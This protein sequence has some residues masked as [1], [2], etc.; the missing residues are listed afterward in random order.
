MTTLLDKI[1]H[2]QNNTLNNHK[3]FEF[4]DQAQGSQKWFEANYS[5]YSKSASEAAAIYFGQFG[6]D[7]NKT[8]QLE[9]NLLVAIAEYFNQY[10]IKCSAADIIVQDNVFDI[11][12]SIYKA[13]GL[14]KDQKVLF[15]L[16]IASYFIQQCHDLEIAVEFLNTDAK[17][18][19]KIDPQTL[20]AALKK[21][22]IKILFLNYPSNVTGAVITKEEALGLAAVIKQHPDLVVI[23]DEYLREMILVKDIEVCSLG[24]IDDIANQVV[25]LGSLKYN[26]AAHLDVAFACL[27]NKDLITKLYS[28]D[29]QIPASI[30]NIAIAALAPSA[31][32]REQLSK[33]IDECRQN[34]EL[35]VEELKNINADLSEHFN[36]KDDF[37]KLFSE[38]LPAGNSIL[39]QFS[40]LKNGEVGINKKTLATDLDIAEFLKAE[41][42]IVMMPGQCCLLPEEEMILRLFLLKSK[43]ELKLGFQKI[44]QA[45]AKIKLANKTLAHVNSSRGG[46]NAR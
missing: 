17:T 25:T 32:N 39:L 10:Q 30:Q 21:H 2:P 31:N 24:A 19:W 28:D 3:A 13:I 34:A 9:K 5:S 1:L 8:A 11:I 36:K 43:E 44:H 16:P 20:A 46:S 14:T 4:L 23:V 6:L 35:I 22:K 40:G 26:A 42:G 29:V 27:K 15:A 38:A 41:T 12:S 18:N 7:K 33:I 45:V 37:I